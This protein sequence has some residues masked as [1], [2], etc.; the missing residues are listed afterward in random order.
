MCALLKFIWA[1]LVSLFTYRN[2]RRTFDPQPVAA[3]TRG[4]CLVCVLCVS[5]V[6]VRGYT[7]ADD[8]RLWGGLGAAGGARALGDGVFFDFKRGGR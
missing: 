2:V 7:E 5:C 3:Y 1:L 6:C 4:V 8:A